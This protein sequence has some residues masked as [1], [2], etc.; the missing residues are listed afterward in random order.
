MTTNKDGEAEVDDAS[1]TTITEEDIKRK[2]NILAM[3]LSGKYKEKKKKKYIFLI[4]P[5]EAFEMNSGHVMESGGP[6]GLDGTCRYKFKGA[7]FDEESGAI[8]CFRSDS[9]DALFAHMTCSGSLKER[10]L[11]KDGKPKKVPQK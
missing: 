4:Q 7:K 6:M 8:E 9:Y 1:T 2:H 5:W 10:V 3:K 11:S